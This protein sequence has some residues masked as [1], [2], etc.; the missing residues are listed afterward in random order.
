MD[1]RINLVL[2][3]VITVYVFTYNNKKKTNL[4]LRGNVKKIYRVEVQKMKSNTLTNELG[5]VYKYNVKM[6]PNLWHGLG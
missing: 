2:G 6:I 1:T 5:S 4:N 3:W